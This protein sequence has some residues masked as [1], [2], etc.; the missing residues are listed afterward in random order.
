MSTFVKATLAKYTYGSRGALLDMIS[1]Q[2]K[3]C[4]L[5]SEWDVKPVGFES[6]RSR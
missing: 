3:R 4:Y 1:L 6:L 5:G 2:N